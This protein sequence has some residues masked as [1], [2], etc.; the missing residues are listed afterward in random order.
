MAIKLDLLE[1]KIRQVIEQLQTLRRENERLRGEC[2]TLQSQAALTNGESRKAQRIL[3]EYEQLR[4]SHEQ[5]AVRVERALQ[6]LDTWKV[7]R[8]PE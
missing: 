1:R 3:A 8:G 2:E 4:R 5:A 7:S 6:K